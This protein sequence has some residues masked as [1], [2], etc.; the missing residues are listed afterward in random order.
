MTKRKL[1]LIYYR[2]FRVEMLGFYHDQGSLV[3]RNI[4][5]HEKQPS[6]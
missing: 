3:E 5:S 1:I 4:S 2:I 6:R